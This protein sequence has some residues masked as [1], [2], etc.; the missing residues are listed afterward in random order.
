MR[1]T[2]GGNIEPI[3]DEDEEEN[4]E[5][6]TFNAEHRMKGTWEG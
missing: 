5:H 3:A 2:G 4:I 1:R 6:R